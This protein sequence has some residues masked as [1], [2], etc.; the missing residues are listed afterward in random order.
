MKRTVC[1]FTVSALAIILSLNVASAQETPP[2][3]AGEE[4]QKQKQQ[5]E[6]LK[7]LSEQEQKDALHKQQQQEI[8][9]K[10]RLITE[11]EIQMKIAEIEAAAAH[12]ERHYERIARDFEDQM[13]TREEISRK[14]PVVVR[15]DEKMFKYVTPEKGGIYIYGSHGQV[16]KPGSSW[17]YSRQV[18]EATFT[19]EFTMSA[20]EETNVN[21]SV[22]GGCAEGSMTVAIIMPDG[23][24]L[25]EVIIDANGSLNWRKNFETD[26]GNGWKNGKWVFKI[27]ARNATGNLRISMNSD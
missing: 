22:S 19:N 21:L 9:L 17:N 10:K 18:M 11:E 6:K 7:T 27:K 8:E 1:L 20:G 12:R 26:Q 4:K 15:P 25:S 13:R 3:K 2:S 16:G 14:Y 24:Q 5:Q 23:K